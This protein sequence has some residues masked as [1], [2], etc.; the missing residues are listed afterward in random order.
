MRP[1]SSKKI[2]NKQNNNKNSKVSNSNNKTDS[3]LKDAKHVEKKII[4]KYLQKGFESLSVEELAVTLISPTFESEFKRVSGTQWPFENKSKAKERLNYSKFNIQWSVSMNKKSPAAMLKTPFGVLFTLVERGDIQKVTEYFRQNAQY[5]N[6]IINLVDN[7]KKSL[8]HVA[9][10]V[11][12]VEMLLF[13]IS[14]K[15]SV[16]FRDKFLRTPLHLACQFGR[17]V[18]ADELLKA[19]SQILARDSI[20][21]TCLH[22]A[23]CSDSTNLVTLILGKEPDLITARDTYGRTPLHYSVWNGTAEQ[24]NIVKK[25]LGSRAEVD[26]LDEEGMTSLHFAAEAG[27]GKIIPILLKYGAN[28]FIRDGRTG[29]T[30][31]ELACNDRIREMIIVY[32]SKD[33]DPKLSLLKLY[34]NNFRPGENIENGGE[35]INDGRRSRSRGKKNK[36]GG[37]EKDAMDEK[38]GNLLQNTYRKKLLELLRAIQLYGVKTMQHMTKPELYSGSWLEKINNANDFFTYINDLSPSEAILSIYNVLYPYSDKLPKSQGE[39]PDLACFFDLNSNNRENLS[40]GNRRNLIKYEGNNNMNNNN[41][42]NYFNNSEIQFLKEQIKRLNEK[43]DDNRNQIETTEM[44]KLKLQIE[45]YQTENDILKQQSNNLNNQINTLNENVKNYEI[46][47]QELQ[48]TANTQK[49]KLI[50]ALNNQLGNLNLE[51][52]I[53][54]N[55]NLNLTQGVALK[56]NGKYINPKLIDTE[57]PLLN[58]TLE[59]EKNV[60]IFLRLC[61]KTTK[62]LYNILLDYDK[63][64]DFYLLK[65][66]FMSVLDY[67]QLPFEQRDTIIKVSGFDTNM[68]LSINHIVSCFLNR[69][70]NKIIKLNQCLFYI[71]EKLSITKKTVEDLYK[72]LAKKC[73]NNKLISKNDLIDILKQF[74]IRE[75]DINGLISNWEYKNNSESINIE[76]LTNHLK[77]RENIINDIM[78]INNE[79][80]FGEPEIS[81]ININYNLNDENDIKTKSDNSNDNNYKDSLINYTHQDLDKKLKKSD[82]QGIQ[83]SKTYNKEIVNSKFTDN[84]NIDNPIIESNDN[85]NNNNSYIGNKNSKNNDYNNNAIIN[86]DNNN[87][88]DNNKS[89]SQIGKEEEN[90]NNQN[91]S[92]IGKEEENENNQN[93]SNI[94]KEEEN[95]DNNYNDFDNQLEEDNNNNDNI[96]SK[97]EEQNE[98]G[99]YNNDN[100][101]N[102]EAL[103]EEKNNDEESQENDIKSSTKKKKKKSTSKKKKKNKKSKE[104]LN[105]NDFI[106]GELKVQVNNIE[107]VMIPKT[108]SLPCSF[109]LTCSIDGI[110]KMLKSREVITE[111]LRNVKFNWATRIVLKKKTLKDLSSFCNINLSVEQNNKN[112]SLGNCQF[113]WEKCLYKD[114]WDKFA[115]NEFFQILTDRKYKKIPMG[116]IKILAKFIPFGS[117]N[118]NYDKSGKKKKTPTN[119]NGIAEEPSH[120]SSISINNKS[121][122]KENINN[123]NENENDNNKI[124]DNNNNNEDIINNNIDNGNI[125]NG[126]IDDENKFNSININKVE[127]EDKVD[128]NENISEINEIDMDDNEE[129]ENNGNIIMKEFDIEITSVDNKAALISKGYYLYISAVEDGYEQEKVSKSNG[130]L[131]NILQ[132]LPYTTNFTVYSYKNNKKLRVYLYIKDEEDNDIG[133]LPIILSN[134]ETHLEKAAKYTIKTNDENGKYVFFLKIAV[135]TTEDI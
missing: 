15:L 128:I 72:E 81:N 7:N 76:D 103:E 77:Q 68:K 61:N 40:N 65:Q 131:K 107:N 117:K 31:I 53:L 133:K 42:D 10:K 106:K 48:K 100:D 18:C 90:E 108:I 89:Q 98:D 71:V 55:D 22:Y 87:Y 14:K 38:I 29:R 134:K 59:E 35:I 102:N 20:G 123:E 67:V 111:D 23:A 97:E 93:Q 60:Y 74:L 109:S 88:N 37:E 5:I 125:D 113:A 50:R 127:E 124:D 129:E 112:I 26:A 45:K 83:F 9:A 51:M 135:N 43:I 130:N 64:N 132:R 94:G 8:L 4:E 85:N 47:Q 126:N 104:K 78:D 27:K 49:D 62:G 69:E 13:L 57:S 32:T 121:E 6:E 75:Q 1:N 63:D 92:N 80:K 25:L 115:V 2:S 54:K 12:N 58:L 119:L 34:G 96:I 99:Y 16:Y 11:G 30:A 95:D 3:Y 36:N 28:P 120:N 73:N 39:E 86:S 24:V 66:E 17:E 19:G 46:K 21:R 41:N 44:T 84:N 114:N 116:N 110:D 70:E 91:Q 105:V 118:S 56:K 82:Y 33:Y 101:K 79:I 122:I 52:N